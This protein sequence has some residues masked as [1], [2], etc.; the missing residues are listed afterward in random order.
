MQE[1]IVDNKRIAKNTVFLYARMLFVLLVTIYTTRVLLNA[2]GVE[3]YGIYY[4]VCGFVT[5]FSFLNTSLSQGIQRFVNF[6]YAKSGDEAV[7]KVF[8]TSLVI[9]VVLIVLLSL[10][11]EL[12]GYYWFTHELVVP[13]ERYHVAW[14]IFQFSVISM[15]INVLSTPYMALVIS[16]ERMNYYALVSIVDAMVKLA[17]A[18][19]LYYITY[20]KLLFYGWSLLII[21]V[22]NLFLYGGYCHIKFSFLKYSFNFD[23][24]LF[25][26]MIS[27]SFW[28]FFGSLSSM[29]K[30]QGTNILLN[31]FFGVIV[32]AAS[33][34][35][36]QVASAVQQLSLNIVIAFRPQLVSA[37]SQNNLER[38][39]KMMSVMSKAGFVLVYTLAI[40]IFLEINYV[41]SLWLGET[42]PTSAPAFSKLSLLSMIVGIFNIPVTQVIHA[43]G[44]MKRYQLLTSLVMF[45]ILPISWLLFKLSFD[46]IF[47]YWI[48]VLIT[49][50]NQ[51]CALI[52]L[53]N[54]F[55]YDFKQYLIDV[56]SPCVIIMVIA[57][58][59]PWFVC[60]MFETSFMRF[61]VVCLLSCFMMTLL[62]YFFLLNKIEKKWFKDFVKHKILV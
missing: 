51:A 33:G 53:Y 24:T 54:V 26:A 49:V 42:V 47:I 37:Y 17:L 10:V 20:D 9:Q 2:L 48:T 39:Q 21:S 1:R 38:V 5:L 4:V 30:T 60:Q 23:K 50:I 28:N 52:I 59:I 14:S 62:S 15:L 45:S 40:P 8:N 61:L 25:S 7:I 6:E 55:K 44:H 18:F 56:I 36:A 34:I 19:S 31:S 43:T 57:P 29:V 11:V 16:F 35:A 3:D 13:D 46:A 12:V 41:L 58:I 22:F 27:F 32:N